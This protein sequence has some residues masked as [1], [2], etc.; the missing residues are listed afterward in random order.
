MK[1]IKSR[2]LLMGASATL[3]ACSATEL[4]G[5]SMTA[6][7][8]TSERPGAGTSTELDDAGWS[9]DHAQP[10]PFTANTSWD[11]VVSANWR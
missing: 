7:A 2:I 3:L 9:S 1:V 10:A 8:P 4:G 11:D 5:L 6:S